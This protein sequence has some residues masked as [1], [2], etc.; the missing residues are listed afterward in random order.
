MTW[1]IWAILCVIALGGVAFLWLRMPVCHW[2][3]TRCEKLVSS[4]RLHPGK[5]TC[6]T[7]V[8]TAYLCNVCASWNTSPASRSHCNDCSSRQVTL[9]VEY[10]LGSALWRWRNQGA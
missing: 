7:K 5:Y 2:Y 10:H 6:G 8:L 3:C 1:H 4:G 9:G